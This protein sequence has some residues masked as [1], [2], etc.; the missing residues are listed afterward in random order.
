[1][2]W[3]RR[4]RVW[5]K[6][7]WFHANLKGIDMTYA[8]II[9]DSF[10][11]IIKVEERPTQERALKAGK[12]FEKRIKGSWFSIAEGKDVIDMFKTLINT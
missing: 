4:P 1:M 11:V 10:N 7:L 3:H 5:P 8:A 9:R 6:A 12:F 2:T